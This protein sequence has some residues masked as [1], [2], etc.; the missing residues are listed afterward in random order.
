MYSRNLDDDFPHGAAA[1]HSFVRFE[2]VFEG[3]HGVGAMLN[4][5]YGCSQRPVRGLKS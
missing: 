1:D 4:F 5:A 3:E 2:N